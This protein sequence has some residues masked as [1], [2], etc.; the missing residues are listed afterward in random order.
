MINKGKTRQTQSSADLIH[1]F[2]ID[3]EIEALE[4]VIVLG[5]NGRTLTILTTT[6]YEEGSEDE[7][8]P[9]AF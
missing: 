7:W 5:N 9:P 2:H 3:N 8:A 1:W 6:D 4:E